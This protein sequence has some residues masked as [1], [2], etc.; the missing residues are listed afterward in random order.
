VLT[1]RLDGTKH[2]GLW[3]P[4]EA[5]NACFGK[6]E[7]PE[8]IP[9]PQVS[10]EFEVPDVAAAA[11]KLR[12]KGYRLISSWRGDNAERLPDDERGGPASSSVVRGRRGPPST[13]ASELGGSGVH[14]ANVAV[15]LRLSPPPFGPLMF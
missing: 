2:F 6:T 14:F 1:H 12:A 11:E 3:P 8:D 9:V 13:S 4:T 5:A 10:I 7:W 15:V